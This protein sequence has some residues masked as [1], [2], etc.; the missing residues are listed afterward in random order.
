MSAL[1]P[2]A[3]IVRCSG[4]VPFVPIVDIRRVS[5]FAADQS[6]HLKFKNEATKWNTASRMASANKTRPHDRNGHR[7]VGA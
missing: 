5:A 4:D 2:K 6:A 3:D 1:T 7:S